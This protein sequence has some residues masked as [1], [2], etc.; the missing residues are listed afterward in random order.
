MPK[1]ILTDKQMELISY[2]CDIVSRLLVGQVDEINRLYNMKIPSD[3]LREVKKNAFPELGDYSYYGITSDK[4]E[5]RSVILYDIHQV[6]RHY[7]A[8]K[9]EDNTP[10]TRDWTRQLSVIYD[11][12]MKL[13]DEPLP[14]VDNKE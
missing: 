4:I 5:N 1:V 2:S 3:L 14:V 11:E 10:E 9:D 8:W 7:L 6:M 12:P 13:S